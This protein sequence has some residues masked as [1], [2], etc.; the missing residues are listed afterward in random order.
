MSSPTSGSYSIDPLRDP[1]WVE[2][3]NRHPRASVFHTPGWLDALQRTYGYRPIVLTTC[4]PTEALTNGIVFCQVRSWLTGKRMVSLPFSDHCEPLVGDRSEL[5][6]ILQHLERVARDWKYV[7]LRPISDFAASGLQRDVFQPSD[8]FFLHLVDLQP[9]LADVFRRFHKDSV[10]RRIRK[11]EK[12][13]LDY[14]CGRSEDLLQK[15]YQLALLTRRRH[16]VPPQPMEWYRNLS[17][18]LGDALDVHLASKNGI[19]VAS[20]ITLRFRNSVV[21]KYGCSDPAFNQL[22][23]TPLLFWKAIEQAKAAG[24]VVF[25]LGRS[26]LDNQGLVTFKDRWGSQRMDLVYRR[27]PHPSGARSEGSAHR[28]AKF[29]LGHLPDSFLKMTGKLVYPHAG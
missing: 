2:L 26:D 22:A 11:A 15:Y 28:A 5:E 3:I 12:E 25:D 4:G 24:A 27:F 14:Q 29:F 18:S 9:D 23:A 16:G 13:N 1:R 10:Q 8:R 21:Y 7:E 6:T 19:P 17:S 20:I